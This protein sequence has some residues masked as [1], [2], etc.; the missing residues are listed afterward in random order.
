MC[1]RHL[2]T[3]TSAVLLLLFVLFL[4]APE[5]VHS[6]FTLMNVSIDDFSPDPSTNARVTYG[7]VNQV[8]HA[9]AGWSVGQNCTECLAQPDPSKVFDQTWHDSSTA[10]NGANI[11][12]ASISFTGVAVYVMGIVISSTPRTS[13]SL[14]NSRIFFQVDGVDQGSFLFEASLG[15]E[16]VYSYNTTFFAKEDLPNGTHNVTMM[17]GD[18]EPGDS[19]CLLDRFIYT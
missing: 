5:T 8:T 19:L 2:I 10:E 13:T 4:G 11:S 15:T 12:F 14:N 9:G 3:T 17:C 7:L 6:S 18:A 16:V 1:K